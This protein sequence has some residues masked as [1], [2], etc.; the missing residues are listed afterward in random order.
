[1]PVSRACGLSELGPHYH[2]HKWN[3]YEGCYDEDEDLAKGET[4]SQNKVDV[5]PIT[6]MRNSKWKDEPFQPSNFAEF[7]N[8]ARAMAQADSVGVGGLIRMGI[9]SITRPLDRLATT[10][11][12][13]C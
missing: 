6:V 8:G 1:M 5:S 12:L 13:L 4:E 11:A 2:D 7:V 10:M 9:I 3:D